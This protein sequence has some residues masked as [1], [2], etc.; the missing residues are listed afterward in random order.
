MTTFRSELENYI[1]EYRQKADRE[2]TH[3]HV[4]NAAKEY[5]NG[6]LAGVQ[7]GENNPA[8]AVQNITALVLQVCVEEVSEHGKQTIR[9]ILEY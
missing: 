9:A 5:I 8:Q 7:L 2:V 3:N 6:Q 4:V 1:A